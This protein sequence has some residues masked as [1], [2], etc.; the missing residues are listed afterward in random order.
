MLSPL[1]KQLSLPLKKRPIR[2]DLACIKELAVPHSQTISPRE[3]DMSSSDRS[4]FSSLDM[5]KETMKSIDASE[6]QPSP[7]SSDLYRPISSFSPL[8]YGN[9]SDPSDKFITIPTPKCFLSPAA[10][11]IGAS[12]SFHL[13]EEPDSSISFNI[14]SSTTES[15]F[16]LSHS[17]PQSIYCTRC[18]K[19]VES[20][21]EHQAHMRRH[22]RSNSKRS[23]R[24]Q[25]PH[26][27]K[28]FVQRS[29]LRTHLRIHSGEKPYKC[30]ISSCSESFSDYSTYTKHVRTHT[31]E[32]PYICPVCMRAFSQS[33][34]M[35]RHLKKVHPKQ[36]QMTRSVSESTSVSKITLNQSR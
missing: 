34:N 23:G 10:S 12:H 33:G 27:S 6:M 32:K 26:C 2:N 7:G 11:N 19:Q 3:I 28:R 31:G 9:D 35:Y 25:C 8:Y 4:S 5:D 22:E 1:Y 21:A 20:R 15:P 18:D 29:S 36:A 24:Y 16:S 14:S 13:K 30:S 17:L